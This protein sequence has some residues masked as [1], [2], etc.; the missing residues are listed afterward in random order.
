MAETEPPAFTGPELCRYQAH[1]IVDLLA[2]RKVSPKELLEASFQR[3]AEVEPAINAMPTLCPDR[4]FAAAERLAEQEHGP[5]WLG[6]LPLGI[7]DLTLVEGVKT[8]FGTAGLADFI[9]QRSDPMVQRI[10]ARGGLVVGKSN[11]P[12]MGA[13]GNT[14]NEVF[15]PTL[16]PWDTSRNPGGSSGGAAAALATG[17]TWLS[18]GSDHGGSLRTPA[19]FCGVVGL[20]PSPGRVA[21]QTEA[22][23][24]IEGTSGPMARS[25]RDC[26]LF[27]D[28]MA[29]YNPRSPISYPGC[30]AGSFQEAVLAASPKI[31]IGFTPDFN[32]LA[33]VDRPVHDHLISVLEKMQA[34][35]AVIEETCPDL[36]GL[37]PS[38]HTLRGVMW[39][40]LTR[41]MPEKITNHF[42]P[43][44]TENI[45]FGQSLSIAD[46]ADAN[47]DRTRLYHRMVSYFE[48]WDVLACPVV[49]CL[50]HLQAE[51]WVREVGGVVFDGYMDWLRHAFLA[52][53][54]G[55][56]AISV[57]VGL[58]PGGL[59]VGLQ[60]IGRPRGE[61]ALLAAA[62]A[63]EM[64]AGGPFPPIDPHPPGGSAGTAGQ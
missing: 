45:A 5:K 4:A 59:P 20:R 21:N 15:G 32:G 9:P 34:A 8:T 27:L 43:V 51:E 62:R 37:E 64:V 28:I 53:V 48:S 25:V 44:L 61:A 41:R 19:A 55:L 33:P 16:N 3:M 38:Y 56:P 30:E 52:T 58:G 10:E 12:E 39:A 24:L 2:R 14:F 63:V 57:P 50:P 54:T 31:R 35:G 29:D 1:E 13:G 22:G 26:A 6:G 46:I 47:L 36:D 7:K 17:E 60:L 49:G 40:T 11:T 23:F 42:K 18:Q